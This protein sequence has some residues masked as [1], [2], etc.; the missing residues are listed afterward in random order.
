M[1]S[2]NE[3]KAILHQVAWTKACAMETFSYHELAA[4]VTM[5]VERLRI[6]VQ[7]WVREGT[8]EFVHR[9]WKGRSYFRVVRRD[10]IDLVGTA[11]ANIWR[12]MRV[13]KSFTTLDLSAHA[14]TPDVTVTE[15]T[16]CEYCDAL[17]AAGY[18]R[19]ER[20]AKPPVR[21]AIYRLIRNT[22]PIPPK[23]QQ[24]IA[25]HDGNLGEYAIIGEGTQ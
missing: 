15:Q 18:L 9:G 12:T 13:M 11:T 20:P 22:G 2:Q 3:R 5:S 17:A 6:V 21:E 25:V 10:Q 16:A 23:P 4:A 7:R 8:A 24:V 19:L 1:T 14:T